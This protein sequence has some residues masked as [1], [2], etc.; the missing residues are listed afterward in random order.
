MKHIGELNLRKWNVSDAPKSRWAEV[1]ERLMKATDMN[2]SFGRWCGHLKR[3]GFDKT[4]VEHLDSIISRARDA[5]NPPRNILFNIKQ[6]GQSNTH[7][8]RG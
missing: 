8:Q 5:E 4:N 2:W 7:G 6:H 3:H 1:V